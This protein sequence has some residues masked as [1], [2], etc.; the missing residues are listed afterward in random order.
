VKSSVNQPVKAIPS[1][2]FVVRLSANSGREATSVVL[3]ISFSWRATSTPS[4]VETMSG[5][6]KSAP[7]RA[8]R[9]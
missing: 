5:S 1:T 2:T 6:T 9:P 8:P 3:E 7:I 4:L